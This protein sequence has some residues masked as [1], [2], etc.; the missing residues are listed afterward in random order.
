MDLRHVTIHGHRVGFRTAGHG[1]VVVLVHGMA[2]S[3][4]TWRHVAPVLAQ[5]FTVV[6]PDLLGHGESAKPRGDYSVSAQANFLR[7]MLTALGHERATVVGQSFGG[8]VAMQ[9]AYQFPEQCERLVLVSSGGLG[10]EVSWLLRGLSAP[11]V[12]HVFPIVCSPAVRDAIGRVAGVLGRLGVRAA[13]VTE[14][15]WLGFAAL[16][17]RDAQI[18]FFRTLRSVIDLGGQTVAANDRLYLAANLPTL[19]MWGARDTLIPVSH[20]RAAADA[21]PGSRLVVFED[22]GHFPH[23]EAP[24]RFLDVLVDFVDSTV[25]ARLVAQ[26]LGE[27]LRNGTLPVPDATA[28]MTAGTPT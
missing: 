18:A 3:S 10:R 27:L 23:C 22:T 14:E 4:A 26:H 8:G 5:R 12:E 11:G 2:G 21:I 13:P 28:P 17:T 24:E 19:I 15:M 6:A 9:F 7:D 16:A 25:P 20:A 1:P